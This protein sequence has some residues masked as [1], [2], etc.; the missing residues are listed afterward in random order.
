M[1]E[2][3][4]EELEAVKN[5]LLSRKLFRYQGKNV[6][7]E[8]SQFE[9]EFAH[10]LSS[11]FSLLTTS[12]TNSLLLALKVLGIGPGDEVIVPAYTFFATPL[13]VLQ[14]GAV[15]VVANIN[16]HLALD[17]HD[18]ERKISK[19]T[20]AIIPVHMDG[21]NADMESL[22]VL[23]KKH[24]VFLVED[25]SQATGG[26][27][28]DHKLGTIGDVGCFSF[29]VEKIITSGEGGAL[30]AKDAALKSRALV[31]HDTCAQFGITHKEELSHLGMTAD[32]MRV[33]EITG[34]I[35]RVQ[36]RK[37]E[38]IL[39]NLRERKSILLNVLRKDHEVIEAHDTEGDCGT[40]LLIKL[41][42]PLT[43]SMAAKALHECGVKAHPLIIRPGH[44]YWQ[45][46]H[47]LV[48]GKYQDARLDPYQWNTDIKD[49]F[50]DLSLTKSFLSKILRIQVDYDLS[51]NETE[52]QAVTIQ[53]KLSQW[54]KK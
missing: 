13:S 26:S 8:C 15:P 19:R 4:E 32:T 34:A 24:G 41:S 16:G 20:K 25:V 51:L 5:V 53:E 52:A 46:Q 6:E 11:S 22:S 35:M 44:F 36:L 2:V 3:N 14:A 9:S 30:V 38:K 47:L 28:K 21:M 45:W 49:S 40:T 29:N 27:F 7:T 48:P 50:K 18:V 39:G 54:R 31:I 42:D 23:S 12:G 1:Y 10:Y 37:L 43:V 33:S 17:T